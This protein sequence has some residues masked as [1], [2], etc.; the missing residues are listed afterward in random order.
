M[1][2]L[3]AIGLLAILGMASAVI[4]F[5]VA[6]LFLEFWPA[7]WLAL[8]ATATGW[9]ALVM[10][11]FAQAPFYPDTLTGNEPQTY[12]G[13]AAGIGV[14]AALAAGWITVRTCRRP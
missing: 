13:T 6:K 1:G 3:F 2:P 5:L 10:M 8:A 7:V 12:L 14:L 11:L 4:V 9:T